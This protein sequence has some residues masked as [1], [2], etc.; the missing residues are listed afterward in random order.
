M[1]CMLSLAVVLANAPVEAF[2]QAATAKPELGTII[3]TAPGRIDKGSDAPS[4]D[5]EAIRGAGRSDALQALARSVPGLSLQ[6]AQNNPFQPNLV[7]RGFTISPLQGQAQGL[8]MY[9]DGGR[10]NQPFGDTVHFDMLP[11]AAIEQIDVLGASPV[12]GLNALGG[13]VVV[14]TKT[15]RSAP[16]LFLSGAFGRYGE[17]EGVAEAGWSDARGSAYVALQQSH[18]DGWRRFSPSTLYNGFADFG[19][20]GEAVGAHVKVIGADSNLTGNGSAPVELLDADYRAVF[21][22]PDNTHNRFARISL[23]PWMALNPTTRLEASLYLQH[24]RQRTL[25]GDV[26]DIEACDDEEKVGLLCLETADEGEEAVTL[27]ISGEVVADT[28][29]GEGYGVLNRSR[30]RT[31]ASGHLVQL[32]DRRPFS[33]GENVLVLGL[34]YDRSRTRFGSST[35]L[36]ALNDNRSVDGLGTIVAQPD[37]SITPVSLMARTRYTGLFLSERLP[38]AG[39]LAVKFGLRWN[40][41]RIILD[42]QIGTALDGSHRFRRLNPGI[43]FDWQVARTIKVRAGYA[44]TN[45]APTPAELACADDEA[46]CSLTNFFVA[47]PPL[48]QVVARTFEAG[49]QGRIRPVEW[50]VSAYRTTNDNDIQF[51]ASDTRGRAF[52]R[53][54]G[55]TRRQGMEATIGY[56][57]SGLKLRAGYAF[58]DATLRTQLLFNAPDNPQANGDGR[59]LVRAGDRLPGVPRHRALVSL[60]YDTERW[61]LGADVQAASGQHLFGD[62]A[63][64]EPRTKAY[65]IVNVSGSVRLAG[66]VRLFGEVR[67]LSDRQYATFGTFSASDEIVL[68]EAPGA[69]DPRS[70]GPG[71]PRRWVAG[72]R[73]SF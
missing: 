56:R 70:L 71:A 42:D 13:A 25:N 5:G 22:H 23:H 30:T 19:W 26:A 17:A 21:T 16:G 40:H 7:Y 60:N 18:D 54:V 10:F 35:E 51:V 52:F 20:D 8:A 44:E 45:R 9:V 33:A 24:L 46:P 58:T 72:M 57:V 31:R 53:N 48:K 2:A 68:D 66:P 50:L 63:N 38:I 47:D 37:G 62:E 73:A 41:A 12:Y 59:I 49:A 14:T 6:D 55:M 61:S 67:N 34:S 65:A 28:L 27:D 4:V 11:E 64:L 1:R 69:S 29:G 43:E 3:V 15:G 32:I 39:G 36:G